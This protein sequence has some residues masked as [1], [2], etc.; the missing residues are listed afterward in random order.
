MD[1]D[2]KQQLIDYIQHE[3]LDGGLDCRI[4]EDTKLI[5]S[6][7]IDSFSLVSLRAFIEKKL[8]IDIPDEIATPDNFDSVTNINRMVQSL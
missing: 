3:Y 8:N 6:G 7:I 5:S 2:F 4:N 1:E